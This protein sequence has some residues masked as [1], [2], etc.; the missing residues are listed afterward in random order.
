MFNM[1]ESL[2]PEFGAGGLVR[3]PAGSALP[4]I[5]PSN[6]YRCNDGIVLIAGNGDT[7]FRRLMRCIGRDDLA[8]QPD[9]QGNA[10]RVKRVEE[11]DAA[12]EAWTR[13]RKVSDVLAAMDAAKVPAGRVYT[14]AD[15][16]SDPQY[17]ARDMILRQSAY[18]GED[19]AVP[20]VVP[21]L[22]ATP[23]AV[24]QRAPR[25]GEH[26]DEVLARMGI[27]P[28]RRATLRAQGVIQ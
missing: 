7:I 9:L 28:A 19:V 5:A 24:R 12:I 18:D 4:G 27:S 10:G 21:K 8:A 11:I 20:G 15:I 22:D 16:A 13:L 6:A 14:V 2:L 1:M 3:E 17:L 26:T 23:G 25:L